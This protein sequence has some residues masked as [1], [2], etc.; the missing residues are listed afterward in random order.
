VAI[1]TRA[2]SPRQRIADTL[3]DW[4]DPIVPDARRQ[5]VLVTVMKNHRHLDYLVRALADIDLSGV[6]TLIID[7]EGDQASLNYLVNRGRESTTYRQISQLRARLRSHTYIQYTATPQAPLLINIIDALSPSFAEVLTPGAGYTGGAVFFGD[8][9][10][11]RFV[12]TIPPTQIF[13]PGQPLAAP[14]QTYR[15]AMATFFVGVAAG[16]LLDDGRGNRSMMVHPHQTRVLHDN[17]Y[18]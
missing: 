7:D 8:D 15:Q 11:R 17:Y 9:G 16:E 4:R 12:R 2:P 13:Q 18:I 14:P 5:G 6:S 10:L 1:D 3:E